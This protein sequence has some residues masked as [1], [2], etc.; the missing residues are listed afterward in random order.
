M[1]QE[2]LPESAAGIAG[3]SCGRCI[4][5]KG[6]AVLSPLERRA[7]NSEEREAGNGEGEMEKWACSELVRVGC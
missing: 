2:Y 7:A 1:K 6:P 4:G 5:R 3:G